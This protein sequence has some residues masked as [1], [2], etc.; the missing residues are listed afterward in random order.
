MV[1]LTLSRGRIVG[2]AACS[3]LGGVAL[4]TLGFVSIESILIIE[5]I[6]VCSMVTVTFW[7]EPR[8][9][10]GSL[11][12]LF[13]SIGILRVWTESVP[14]LRLSNPNNAM[15][16]ASQ[17][18]QR[19]EAEVVPRE[20]TRVRKM[21]TERIQVMLPKEEAALLTGILYGERL[22]SKTT[23]QTFRR[24]GLMHIVA[25]SGAN[26]SILVLV[27]ARCLT[28]F[29]L[30]RNQSWGVLTGGIF[31]F[32]LFVSPSASVTRAAVM[33]SLVEL[34]PLVGRLTRATRLL[35]IA[36][37][38]FV[39]WQ[40]SALLLDAGF[41]LSFLAMLGLICLGPYIDACF[42]RRVPALLRETCVSTIA[43]TMM[44]APYLAWIFRSWSLLGCLTNLIIVPLIPWTM[45]F[46]TIALLFPVHRILVLP[47]QGCL[48]FILRIAHLT[49][50]VTVGIWE[51]IS[52][53]WVW[54][55][56]IYIFL[57]SL[58]RLGEQRKR[59]IHKK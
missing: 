46:G 42:P 23:Q 3:F 52:F 5:G 18:R 14:L 28:R 44:T 16:I 31:L 35:L 1:S 7:R 6:L 56:S 53:S 29:G 59:L 33:G 8:A 34:A 39:I 58:W 26:I 22:F 19:R 13:C 40:P 9:F 55:I 48:S 30:P 21:L 45:L 25:V 20:M 51:N 41:I 32:V 36:A 38:F 2:I 24:A 15:R 11:C 49:D 43:A 47:V 50:G 17:T 12:L 4:A 57:F 27:I 10:T 54:M 37:C